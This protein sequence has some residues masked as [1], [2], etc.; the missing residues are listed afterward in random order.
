MRAVRCAVVLIAALACAAPGA[1]YFPLEK[2]NQ[3]SYTMSNG[4]EMTVT[5]VGHA[6]IGSVRCA[7]VETRMGWQTQREYMAADAEGVKTYMTQ[8]QDQEM[9]HDPP[10]LRVKLPV[11]EGQTWISTVDQFGMAITTTN[12]WLGTERIQTPAGTFD[13]VKVQSSVAVPGQPPMVSI[14]YYADGIGG[15]RQTMQAGGQEISAVLTATNVR[16]MQAPTPTPPA[17]AAGKTNCPQCD[18]PVDAGAKFC[19]ACGAKLVQ[20]AP[21][22]TC[23]QCGTDLPAGARFCPECG[24]QMA[25]TASSP[26]ADGQDRPALQTGPAMEKYQSPDGKVLLYK[27]TDWTVDQEALG[28]GAFVLSVM[29]PEEKAAVMFV[30]FPTDE[31]IQDSVVLAARCLTALATE[32][33]SLQTTRIHSTPERERTIAEITLTDDGEKGVGRGYF[34]HT[35]R[36]GTVYI[37][38]AHED[39]WDAVRTT[40]TTVAANLA[41]APEGVA[42]VLERGRQFTNAA[43]ASQDGR[44][45]SPAAMIQKASHRA[46]RQV[47]LR[48]TALSDQSLML[49]I[50]RGWSLQGQKIQFTTF[51]NPQTKLRGVGSGCHTVMPSQFAVP[52]TINA[53][54]QPPLQAL[55]L[56]L[57]LGEIGTDLEL[58][59]E[60]P[61]EQAMPD[62][63]NS[64]RQLQA[65]GLQV[66]ARLMHVRFRS[67]A[68]GAT[69]RGVFAVQCIAMPMSP[70]WQVM[71][72][73]SWAPDEEYEEWLPLYLRIG[74]STQVNQQWFGGEMQ[75]RYARQ[76]QLNR[77]LQNSIAESNQ[78]FDQYMDTLQDADRSR[79][80]ISHMWSQTTLGQGTWVAENEGARVYRTDS[81]GIEGPEGRIDHSAFNTTNF[82][83]QNP[84]GGELEMVDTR[85]EY[86]KYIANR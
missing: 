55:G 21:V 37:L 83:G 68:T 85:A 13:C 16:P 60:C 24:K 70:V 80:Y 22:T 28:D 71:A 62:A 18:A 46:G 45:L 66:D 12:R 40:L 84:W 81:W 53:P 82:T 34:F 33:P 10:V 25:A 42:T 39:L 79:D 38:V 44:V 11:Q 47:P 27:P 7:V 74:K 32:I 61:T 26:Q 65:Q 56:V 64:I 6:Q 58:L 14:S 50:P 19:P 17:E 73:G 23:P 35:Q 63:S 57:Q 1:N 51:D 69:L 49:Q 76:Q 59:G 5:V 3:W 43:A 4:A 86:E 31:E 72:D 15:V 67:I 77:N 36:T 75:N 52:G 20:R 30:T 2:G 8:A 78:A 48:R 41:F 54:Y 9:R 29:E